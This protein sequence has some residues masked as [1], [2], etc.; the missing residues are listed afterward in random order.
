ME[1]F[2][3]N[4]IIKTL[5]ISPILNE[6]SDSFREE[7]DIFTDMDHLLL[8]SIESD[9][10]D[11]EGDIHFIEELLSN[12]SISLPENESSNFYL[13]D[14][15]S[16][17]SPPPEP[18]DVE[19]FFDFEP[20]LGEVISAMINNIDELNEDKCFDPRNEID[21]FANIEDDDYFFFVFFI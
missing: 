15:P 2:L 14:D 19:F 8:P 16:F 13:Q 7:I 21:V 1:N 9:D 20:N 5:T 3:A 4:T 12:D 6:D 10:Y 11:S 17:P 18:P